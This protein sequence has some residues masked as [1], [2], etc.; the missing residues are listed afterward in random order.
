[1]NDALVEPGGTVRLVGMEAV[2]PV[3]MEPSETGKPLAGAGPESVTVHCVELGESTDAGLQLSPVSVTSGGVIVTTPPAPL[4]AMAFPVGS[5]QFVVNTWIVLEVEDVVPDIVKFA[6]AT[7]PS[8]ITFAFRGLGPP[9]AM[10][11]YWPAVRLLHSMV[12]AA[13]EAAVP[14]VTF[15]AVKSL[16]ENENV[17]IT[18]AT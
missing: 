10:H 8:G 1:M 12:L 7:I 13:V 16:G 17:H 2:A 3:A 15:T 6:A 9:A 5:D 18:P 14:A 4:P 11:T